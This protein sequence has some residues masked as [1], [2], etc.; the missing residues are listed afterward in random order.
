M[1]PEFDQAYWDRVDGPIFEGEIKPL[2]PDTVL[3]FHTH[4]WRESDLASLPTE[5]MKKNPSLV[6]TTNHFPVSELQQ[7]AKWLFPGK[8]Y[9][10]LA[11]GMPY[12]EM[13]VGRNNQHIAEAVRNSPDV[14]GLMM[15]KP[16]DTADQLRK[17][18]LEGRFVGFKP[19]FTFVPKAQND[20]LLDD[21]L[22]DEHLKVAD[23]FG[24]IVMIDV[25]RKLR[26][27][28]PQ[29]IATLRRISPRYPRAK[30]IVAHVGRA[31]CEWVAFQALSQVE[32]LPNVYLDTSFIQNSVTFQ[33]L[34]EHVD[35]SRIMYG[36]DLPDAAI[37]GQVACVN[38][39]NLF[40][41]RDP[42]PWSLY[43][44]ENPIECTYMVY[45]ELRAIRDGGQRA[46]LSVKDLQPVFYAN[47]R[48]LIDD[49]YANLPKAGA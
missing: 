30:L 44:T 20:V 13:D 17:Q 41:T 40:V 49:V 21:M 9:Q 46:G 48:R 28:D 5:E 38:G 34:F 16:S 29:N 37:H 7:T 12:A 32:E 42:H 14:A 31:Y 19:Y 35:V 33:Y 18:V 39:I 36:T 1:G 11:I 24:L 23:E 45:E 10:V 47:A 26:L 25:P 27:T 8:R 6:W 3:D 43:R 4:A 22:T 15:V 2:I